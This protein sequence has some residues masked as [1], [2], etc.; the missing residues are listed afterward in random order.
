[1]PLQ[2]P[3]YTIYIMLKVLFC[4]VCTWTY[5]VKAFPTL[6][7]WQADSIKSPTIIMFTF[8][9]SFSKLE[10]SDHLRIFKAFTLAKI[11]L[12]KTRVC[13]LKWKKDELCHSSWPFSK[14]FKI[15]KG[16]FL[17][18]SVNEFLKMF[19]NIDQTFLPP[20]LLCVIYYMDIARSWMNDMKGFH[21]RIFEY[22]FTLMMKLGCYLMKF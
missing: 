6:S 21:L 22:F 19:L 18:F 1:M 16:A 9:F 10:N 13:S 3:P 11:N 14:L 12:K 7:R 17:F 8:F 15:E 20:Y 2:K 5:S 4:F